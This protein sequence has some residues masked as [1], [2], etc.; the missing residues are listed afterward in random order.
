MIKAEK[1]LTFS[2]SQAKIHPSF[3]GCEGSYWLQE[4]QSWR[5]ISSYLFGLFL[6]ACLPLPL[7]AGDDVKDADL[8]DFKTV[9]TAIT[10]RIA[11]SAPAVNVQASYLG[12]HTLADE[13]GRLTVVLVEEDSPA[14]GVGVQD[15]DILVKLAG[16]ASSIL[17]RSA[18]FCASKIPAD[19]VALELLR[20]RQPMQVNATLTP[21]SRPLEAVKPIGKG[22]GGNFDARQMTTWKKDIYQLAVVAIDFPDVKHN[23]KVTPKHWEESLFSRNTYKKTSVTGQKVFGSMND[24]YDEISYGAFHVVGK[25]FDY[26]QVSKKRMDY[27]QTASKTALL[28]E[29]LDKLYERDGKEALA[30]YDGI[31]F[32]FAGGRVQSSVR[33]GLFWPHRASVSHNGKRWPYFICPEGGAAMGNISVITHEFGH[34][35]G[36]PDL[37]A[38]AREPRLGRGRHLVHHVQPGGNGRPQHFSAWS[39][40]QLDWIKPAAD[41]SDDAAE[42]DTVAHLQ[43]AEGMLQGAGPPR[44]QRILLCWKTARIRASTPACRARDC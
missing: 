19:A 9:E 1:S 26:V 2:R 43:I 10:T 22:K 13:Q 33:G 40:E 4:F 41:R 11:K 35:L 27:S 44:R 16:Q 12:V 7:T 24:F 42:A 5:L 39:K 3:V 20:D 15:G 21:P 29:A 18:S 6:L 31:F 36:L 30:K 32:M 23:D 8:A 34:M 17:K 38:R 25:V 28:T 37:Y 14:A